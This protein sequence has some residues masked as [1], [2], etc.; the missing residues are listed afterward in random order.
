[1]LGDEP[2][3]LAV[4][5]G[6]VEDVEDLPSE[7]CEHY[8][9]KDQV[10]GYKCTKCGLTGYVSDIREKGC[11]VRKPGVEAAPAPV[12][13]EPQEPEET[14]GF[15][16]SAAVVGREMAL[17]AQMEVLP[18]VGENVAADAEAAEAVLQQ[19]LAEL[20]MLEEELLMQEL[21]E[22]EL[23]LSNL[24]AQ[25]LA[26]SGVETEEEKGLQQPVLESL[27]VK[28]PETAPQGE[29][30]A[31]EEVG[32]SSED[33]TRRFKRLRLASAS[34]EEPMEPK[35]T[36]C[37]V[38]K[39]VEEVKLPDP[40]D[41]DN[42]K[43][44]TAVDGPFASEPNPKYKEYWKRF[45]VKP[46]A[47]AAAIHID[48]VDTLPHDAVAEPGDPSSEVHEAPSELPQPGPTATSEPLPVNGKEIPADPF[49]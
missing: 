21:L 7:A 45:V 26:E 33:L 34:F 24:E 14:P 48:N 16:A 1:M 37:L 29:I 44:F 20:E 27:A 28:N 6:T 8:L 9:V 5:D 36:D 22:E 23:E 35:E 17:K 11:K 15:G 47:N 3:G 43:R 25:L 46:N 12:P 18:E 39:E 31:E 32:T 19:E 42:W 38:V 2:K 41:V 30:A 10:H 4:K 49:G 40:E 13:K